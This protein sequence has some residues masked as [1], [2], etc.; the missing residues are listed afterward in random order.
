MNQNLSLPPGITMGRELINGVSVYVVRDRQLGE[1]GRIVLQGTPEDQ[2]HL[3]FEVAGD[4][5]DPTTKSRMQRFQPVCEVASKAFSNHFPGGPTSMPPL[6]TPKAPP[7]TVVVNIWS[8]LD[9]APPWARWLLRMMPSS[10]DALKIMR[11]KC[12]RFTAR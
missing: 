2:A 12:I 11:E 1:I 4:P 5:D 6:V 9:V 10:R 3:S 7:E 8:V